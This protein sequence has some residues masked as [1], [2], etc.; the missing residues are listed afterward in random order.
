MV[1]RHGLIVS[2]VLGNYKLLLQTSPKFRK[3]SFVLKVRLSRHFNPGTEKV[4]RAKSSP[5]LVTLAVFAYLPDP[6][7]RTSSCKRSKESSQKNSTAPGTRNN[8]P[9]EE[10]VP[11]NSSAAT[12]A[13]ETKDSS[14]VILASSGSTAIN[15]ST[16]VAIT[17]SSK[18]ILGMAISG[19]TTI[20]VHS[21]HTPAMERSNSATV[22]TGRLSNSTAPAPASE[23]RT[24]NNPTT[25]TAISSS[26]IAPMVTAVA[27]AVMVVAYSRTQMTLPPQ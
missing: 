5:A 24:S 1:S 19:N 15:N 14:T 22:T 11:N 21:N 6:S 17:A 13:M 8:L 26:T 12:R 10:Q 2:L 16:T 3:L 7:C 25:D 27:R 23:E 20:P 9:K 18:H 4:Y